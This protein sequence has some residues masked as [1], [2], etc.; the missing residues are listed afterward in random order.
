[1][2]PRPDGP[3]FYDGEVAH[4]DTGAAGAKRPALTK[5]RIVAL[6]LTYGQSGGKPQWMLVQVARSM[7]TRENIWK[8]I[9]VDTLLPLSALIMLMTMIVWVGT[10]A[11]LAPLLRLRREVEGRSPADLTPLRVEATPHELRSLVRALNDLLAAVRQRVDAQKRFIADA[12]HQLRTPLTGLKTQ[13]E[14]AM[15]ETDDPA[16]S[17]RLKLVHQSAT[18]SAHLISR[19]LMLARAEPEATLVQEKVTIDLVPFVHKTVALMV[20]RALRAGVDLGMGEPND[21][22]ETS[23]PRIQA[24]EILLGEALNNVLENAIEYAGRGSEITVSV[25]HD[26]GQACIVVSD[27]GPG[28][29]EADRARVFERFVRATEQGLGCGLGLS[30]VREI[31]SQHGGTVALA[32]AEPHGLTVVMRLPAH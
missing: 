7:A 27:T 2:V 28:I 4:P 22:V 25:A 19:L 12:A 6:Y 30:I 8:L 15:D 23:S 17:A 18:R 14:L 21:T 24:N 5:V 11:G 9:L 32:G 1:M 16:L 29:A 20:P 10:G 3:Y 13:T 26:A 31:I